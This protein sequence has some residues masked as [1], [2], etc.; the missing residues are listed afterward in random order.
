VAVRNFYWKLDWSLSEAPVSWPA[1]SPDL[2]PLDY[3]F[4]WGYLNT[5]V[6]VT[7]IDTKEILRP[8]QQFA[9]EIT[10]NFLFHA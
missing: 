3:S 10:L 6:C 5:E 2:N 9:N 4:L 7:V 1:H 8:I